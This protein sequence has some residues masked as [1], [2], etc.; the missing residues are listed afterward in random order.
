MSDDT[1]PI[2]NTQELLSNQFS[3]K[4]TKANNCVFLKDYFFIVEYPY[5]IPQPQE[6]LPSSSPPP[7]AAAAAAPVANS[8]E[9]VAELTKNMKLNMT[10]IFEGQGYLLK[11]SLS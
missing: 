9:S 10:K 11:L 5:V 6:N 7:P 1:E 2:G 3:R 8:L 4:K